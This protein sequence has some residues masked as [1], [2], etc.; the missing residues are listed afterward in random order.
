[1][2]IVRAVSKGERPPRLDDPPLSDNAWGLIHQCWAHDKWKRPGI[3]DVVETMKS[4]RYPPKI[5]TPATPGSRPPLGHKHLGRSNKLD[6]TDRRLNIGEP[7]SGASPGPGQQQRS[8]SADVK[9]NGAFINGE[10]LSLQG[11]EFG[12]FELKSDDIVVSR[13][14]L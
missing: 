7:S 5:S 14:H 8:A 11:V 10:W 3:R 4:W 13:R 9:R 6:S 2:Y 12:P 1:M